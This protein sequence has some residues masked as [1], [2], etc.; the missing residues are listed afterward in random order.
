MPRPKPSAARSSAG[1]KTMPGS[2]DEWFHDW[3]EPTWR[4]GGSSLPELGKTSSR[5]SPSTA[6]RQGKS[7]TV[8]TGALLA[9]QPAADTN[10]LPWQAFRHGRRT[11]PHHGHARPPLVE[12]SV[13]A[14][15][16]L[17]RRGSPRGRWVAEARPNLHVSRDANPRFKQAMEA[18]Q[19]FINCLTQ[20]VG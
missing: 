18:R 7:S 15:D 20:L 16:H 11:W 13:A 4:R 1:S 17:K 14:G 19:P 3:F 6:L 5:S 9:L 12:H 10:R 2:A 8:S